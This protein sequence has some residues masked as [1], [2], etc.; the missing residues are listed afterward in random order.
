MKASCSPQTRF[1]FT[2]NSLIRLSVN[3]SFVMFIKI[4]HIELLKV[5]TMKHYIGFKHKWQKNALQSCS[6]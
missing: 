4:L 1:Q 2:P 5:G 6:V 3:V